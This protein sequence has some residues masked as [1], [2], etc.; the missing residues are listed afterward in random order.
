MTEGPLITAIIPVYKTP[1]PFLRACIES[2]QKQTVQDTQILLVDDGSPDDC[3]KICDE[4]AQA[5]PRIKVLHQENGGPSAARNKG[6]Q[7]AR[8]HYLTFVDSDDTL[9]P[10]AWKY[11]ICAMKEYEVECVVFGWINN[12]TGCPVN[13]KVAERPTVLTALEAM[14]QIAGDND[15]CGGGYPW[16]KVWD[17][18][19]IRAVNGGEIPQFDMELFAYE[20]K[21]WIIQLLHGLKQVVLLPEVY[22]DY[23]LVPSSL[24]NSDEAWYRRQFNA[25]LAYD[26]I[27]DYLESIDRRACRSGLGKYFRFCFIDLRNMHSWRKKDMSRYKRTKKCLLKVCKRLRLGDLKKPKHIMAWLFCRIYCRF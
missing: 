17:A 22:Y 7:H 3:G 9:S 11:A 24:T 5:D 14:A 8:G 6:L 20:D 10:S 23:R 2:I 25:Y 27:C 13:R 18:D 15:A 16:N 1:E 12:E 19:A 4:Y 26:K 21:Y